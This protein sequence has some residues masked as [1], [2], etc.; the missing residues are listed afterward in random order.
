MTEREIWAKSWILPAFLTV[1]EIVGE[2]TENLGIAKDSM[3]PSWMVVP[4]TSA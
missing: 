2:P 1:A 4:A 3:T